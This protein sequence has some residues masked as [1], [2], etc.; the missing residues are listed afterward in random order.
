MPF[1]RQLAHM[2]FS[3]AFPFPYPEIPLLDTLLLAS[4]TLLASCSQA[5]LAATLCCNNCSSCL[6][7][8]ADT[9]AFFLL[10]SSAQTLS[11]SSQAHFPSSAFLQVS[12]TL[13]FLQPSLASASLMAFLASASLQAFSASATFQAS[14]CYCLCSSSF[15]HLAC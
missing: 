6:C 3:G 11:T 5:T 2:C 9:S 4:D 14:P 13:A 12:L 8:T 7:H 10:S 15:M 1:L